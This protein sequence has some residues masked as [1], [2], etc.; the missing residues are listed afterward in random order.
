MR[1]NRRGRTLKGKGVVIQ[2]GRTSDK[3]GVTLL[4]WEDSYDGDGRE[5]RVGLTSSSTTGRDP[6]P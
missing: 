2:G 5:G 6:R 3:K 4:K 1:G